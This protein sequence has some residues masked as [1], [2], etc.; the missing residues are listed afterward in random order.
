[1]SCQGV[2]PDPDDQDANAPVGSISFRS[3]DGDAEDA[4][5]T[6]CTLLRRDYLAPQAPNQT[7][8][9]SACGPTPLPLSGATGDSWALKALYVNG[10]ESQPAH[11]NGLDVPAQVQFVP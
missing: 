4:V 6:P 1:P 5:G 9:A 3:R 7:P 10:G 8:Y 2:Q 11:T